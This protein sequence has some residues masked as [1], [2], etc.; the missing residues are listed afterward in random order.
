[1]KHRVWKAGLW[2][3]IA[4]T[5][6]A[7]STVYAAAGAAAPAKEQAPSAATPAPA[8]AATTPATA[9]AP[10]ATTPAA[11]EHTEL[12]WPEAWKAFHN[13]TPWLSMGLDDRF[14]IEAGENWDDLERRQHDVTIA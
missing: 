9:A 4:L 8:A 13:P 7:G 10:P 11:P 3:R 6:I 14:R 1:M 5:V 12:F 2:W